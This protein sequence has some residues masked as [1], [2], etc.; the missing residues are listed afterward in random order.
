M[1]DEKPKRPLTITREELYGQA[2]ETPIRRL[3]QQYAI[4]DTGL[5]KICRRLNVPYPPRS[6]WARKTA[7]QKVRQADFPEAT[8]PHA[9]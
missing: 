5:A 8:P 7:G 3:S 2:W 6:Y 4:S 9:A 1:T